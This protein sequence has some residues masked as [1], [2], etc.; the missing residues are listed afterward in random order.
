MSF[1][2][3]KRTYDI[4]FDILTFVIY[5]FLAIYYGTKFKYIGIEINTTINRKTTG[6]AEGIPLVEM[7]ENF[8]SSDVRLL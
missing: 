2:N 5:L 4:I 6:Y 7:W 8:F 3:D 1:R